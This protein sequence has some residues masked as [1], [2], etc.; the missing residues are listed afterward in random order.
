MR[1]HKG[2]QAPVRRMVVLLGLLLVTLLG[3]SGP[4]AGFSS[5]TVVF[6]GSR[7]HKVVALTFDDGWSPQ[8]CLKIY[9]TLVSKHVTATWFPNAVYMVHA[10]ALW[11]KIAAKFPIA[12]HTYDHPWLTNL[13][14]F[15][16][17][18]QLS[19]DEVLAEQ[20][21]GHQMVKVFRP[22]YGAYNSTVLRAAGSLGY[23]KAIMWDVDDGDTQGAS[24]VSAIVHNAT[25]G[26]NGS[27]VLMHC[28]PSLT[29]S[30]VPLIIDSYRR[31]GFTFV[32]IPQLLALH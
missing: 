24:S 26:T 19:H 2:R 11:H 28:G 22:P 25:K 20:I 32:T 1:S 18:W 12:N 17:R 13:G 15:Q 23:T 27:I 10:T 7:A 5:A 31:R 3:S 29:P 4:A 14:Y 21:I 8:N 16:I 6:S 9:N 30:A